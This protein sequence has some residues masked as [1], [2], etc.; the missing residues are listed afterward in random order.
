MVT[1]IVL[2][3]KFTKLSYAKIKNRIFV[4]PQIRSFGNYK[5]FEAK[6][7]LPDKMLG[8]LSTMLCITFG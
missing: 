5:E 3:K 1:V 4:E 7:L 6:I 8:L 2:C